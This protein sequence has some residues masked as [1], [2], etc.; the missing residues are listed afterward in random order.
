V[1]RIASLQ[2]NVDWFRFWL[3]DYR[4]PN[5]EDPDQYARWELMR[6]E[7]LCKPDHGCSPARGGDE[8]HK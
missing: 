8:V 6:S 2:R 3:Q 4:R 1:A 7:E 5:P